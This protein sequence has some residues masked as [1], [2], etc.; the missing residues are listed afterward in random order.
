MEETFEE[1]GVTYHAYLS[2]DKSESW[3]YE[4]NL[5]NNKEEK[6]QFPSEINGIKTT[7]IGAVDE[8]YEPDS[9]EILTGSAMAGLRAVETVKLSDNLEKISA[10]TFQ[11]DSK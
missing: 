5:K 8:L 9:V 1:N 4:I 11:N 10:Y 7:V 6:L 3:I 2:K